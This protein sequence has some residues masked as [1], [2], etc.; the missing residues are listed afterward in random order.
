MCCRAARW[1]GHRYGSC[2]L[3]VYSISLHVF[4]CVFEIEQEAD[5]V[6]KNCKHLF[7]FTEEYIQEGPCFQPVSSNIRQWNCHLEC[8]D[9]AMWSKKQL[10]VV[11]NSYASFRNIKSTFNQDLAGGLSEG[12][13]A[14]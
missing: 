11:L 6:W 10:Q 13:W 3:N 12:L 2:L 7:Y 4:Q 9:G 14:F 8:T 1:I 5:V